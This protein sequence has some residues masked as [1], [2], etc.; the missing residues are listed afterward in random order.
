MLTQT[1][2]RDNLKTEQR[3]WN[4]R[5]GGMYMYT[6]SAGYYYDGSSITQKKVKTRKLGRIPMFQ[7]SVFLI[8]FI[9]SFVF[10]AVIHAYATNEAPLT[11][12]ELEATPIYETHI[13]DTG[14]SLWVIAK[15]Y[16]PATIDIRE[17]VN[18]I[19]ILNQLDTNI[20]FEGQRLL[21]PSI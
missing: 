14:Q 2:V 11:S 10:G 5:L 13:V 15:Q 17:Y 18:E 6:A 20:L 8:I 16:A 7:V 9:L 21:L 12:I 4:K 19:I 3:F 1:P